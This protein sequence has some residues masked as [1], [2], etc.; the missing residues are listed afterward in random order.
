[1]SWLD[2]LEEVAKGAAVG[3]GHAVGGVL[4]ASSNLGKET[5]GD[6]FYWMAKL[7]PGD[8]LDYVNKL[9][10][11]PTT[12]QDIF[13]AH[14]RF[15]N[16]SG[17]RGVWEQMQSENPAITRGALDVLNPF[18]PI[19]AVGYAA[20]VGELRAGVQGM[21]K[22]G[23]AMRTADNAGIGSRLLGGAT[24]IAGKGLWGA[25]RASEIPGEKLTQAVG[26]GFEKTGIPSLIKPTQKTLFNRNKA[27]VF[28]AWGE[29]VHARKN[30]LTLPPAIPEPKFDLSDIKRRRQVAQEISDVI[31][32]GEGGATFSLSV[33]TPE[34]PTGFAKWNGP[35]HGYMVSV[36]G[37]PPIKI[38][39]PK[40]HEKV[41]R[42]IGKYKDVFTGPHQ[43]DIKIGAYKFNDNKEFSV[44][45]SMWVP[46]ENV[47]TELAKRVN[48]ESIYNMGTGELVQT[49][50]SGVTPFKSPESVNKVLDEVFPAPAPTPARFNPNISDKGNAAL[51]QKLTKWP[52]GG[53][54]VGEVME[55]LR[56][57]FEV[58]LQHIKDKGLVF[59]PELPIEQRRS[60]FKGDK[61]ATFVINEFNKLRLDPFQADADGAA[62]VAV[63][64]A[65]EKEH[66][67]V[68]KQLGKY[69]MLRAVW[70]EQALLSGRY[71][72]ANAFG[73]WMAQVVSGNSVG[74]PLRNVWR[75]VR[76][77]GSD[78]ASKL[79]AEGASLLKG[80]EI[81]RRYGLSGEPL[82]IARTH[83]TQGLVE[84][85]DTSRS[86]SARILGKRFGT[87]TL[88]RVAD[89]NIGLANGIEMGFRD[90]LWGDVFESGMIRDLHTLQGTLDEAARKSGVD[91]S[92][93]NLVTGEGV[94]SLDTPTFRRQL[95]DAGIREGQAEHV[96]RSLVNMRRANMDNAVKEVNRV[97]FSYERTNLD[98]MVSKFVPFHYWASR[99]TRFYAENTVR[100]PIWLVNYARLNEGMDRMADDPGLSARAKGFVNLLNS[101][102][103][104]TLMANPLGLIGVAKIYQLDTSFTPDGET[105]LG[106]IMRIG[107]QRGIGLFPWVDSIFNYMGVYGDT[108]EPDPAGVRVR[109][110]VGAG[111]QMVAARAGSPPPPA[112]YAGLNAKLRGWVSDLTAS[113]APDWIA[114][115]VSPKSSA[116][117]S[118]TSATLDDVITSR[119]IAENPNLT[120]GDL[121]E[122]LSDPDRPEYRSAYQ[123][124]AAAG[125]LQ[126]LMSFTLPTNFRV[127][128]NSRDVN[129]AALNTIRKFAD[130][131]KTAPWDYTPNTGDL[132]FATEYKRKTGKEWKPGD[133][134]KA[135]LSRDLAVAPP[136]ARIFIVQEAEYRS[137]GTPSMQTLNQ[138]WVKIKNGEWMPPGFEGQKLEQVQRDLVADAW[139]QKS[140]PTNSITIL[141][142]LQHAYRD[143]HPEYDEF[144]NWESQMYNISDAYGTLAI[145]RDQVM[146]HNPNAGKYFSAQIDSIRKRMPNS[147]AEQMIKELDR[148]TISPAT[149]FAV[150]GK[151]G[152][153]FDQ[154]PVSTGGLP[155]D[156][157]TQFTTDKAYSA[158]SQ[159]AQGPPTPW[160]DA[161]QK[162]L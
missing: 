155:F 90:S 79:D 15:G 19:N 22:L 115:P 98:D 119:I 140:D 154:Q 50:G 55:E 133:F 3:A 57:K 49:G 87:K 97:F 103:G 77:Q 114:Q 29:H 11:D 83:A 88:A 46:D 30:A 91:M 161:L 81:A 146:A 141:R 145:Y 80:A 69:E 65:L 37:S 108:F 52:H 51:S 111:V 86:V 39:D 62:F 58:G 42:A 8:S 104:F 92:H 31:Y 143:T 20:G 72:T 61:E 89:G 130:E 112:P 156:P 135:Q 153:Q 4:D 70:G 96:V 136:G 45:V 34:N 117:G 150:T 99:A 73:N 139:L 126:Q 14:E 54:T 93:V 149:W 74:V 142:Q 95:T 138:T 158:L 38:D 48:Q 5:A 26:R 53:R 18:D 43:R 102:T 134:D 64:K 84:N 132:A 27:D 59:S 113:L 9:L 82:E 41:L 33:P 1:M 100:H 24:E 124:V 121:V 160:L 106:K 23:A 60:Y 16:Y 85:L 147:S 47:A 35:G 101:P 36:A 162:R 44:D 28:N 105:E 17:G 63:S 40:A 107:K 13:D 109:A 131:S 122:I 151:A 25:V 116:D 152:S 76:L 127:R 56:G 94:K 21:G 6:A 110:L 128:E 78:A 157:A 68:A 129:R 32:S 148:V 120:N 10:H 67:I 144:K 7:S 66:G 118:I 123:D 137:L 159:P 75:A 12:E 71:H 125:L 2:K